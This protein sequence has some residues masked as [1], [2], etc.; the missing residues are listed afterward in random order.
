[1][2]NT[3]QNP[4]DSL[5]GRVQVLSEQLD[6]L[7][8]VHARE[9]AQ[10]LLSAVMILYGDGLQRIMSAIEDSG[11]AGVAICDALVA[12]PAV[13]SLLLIHDLYPVDI[14]TRVATALASVRPYMESHGGNVEL[15]SLDDGIAHLRLEGSCSGCSASQ[16]TLELAIKQALDEHAPDLVGLEVEGVIEMIPG[17]EPTGF[18][19]PLA[20]VVP[21]RWVRVEGANEISPGEFVAFDAEGTP[22]VV[23]NVAGTLLAYQDSCAACGAALRNGELDGRMLRCKECGVEFDLP[24][25]GRAAGDGP[26]QLAPVPFLDGK[27]A[28]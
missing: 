7:S 12:D 1:V 19:L 18:E 3:D 15:I 16:A 24:R 14:E 5:V 23:A 2:L 11:A 17:P 9:L 25:A 13:G 27:V 8:D 26:L 4:A 22:L 10:E 6:G 20:E 28:V 21:P